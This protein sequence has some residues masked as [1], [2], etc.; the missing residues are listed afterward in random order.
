MRPSVARL[1]PPELDTG[2]Q[3]A[4]FRVELL[5]RY[6]SLRRFLPA[7]LDVMAFEATSAGRAVLDALD[8]L[9]AIEGRTG[10]VSAESVPLQLV[11]GQWK[12]LVLANAQL[13]GG[14][15]DRRAYSFCVLEALQRALDRR[16]V[17]VS[18]SGRYSD[19]RAKLLS[20]PAREAARLEICAS[21]NHHPDPAHALDRLGAELDGAYRPDRRP[22][23]SSPISTRLN[24]ETSSS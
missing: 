19:P 21:L 14:E 17:F 3:D 10:R 22:P 16:D 20:G 12:R 15:L 9:H 13:G 8:A 4:A 1:T 5:R 2:G 7:L 24:A 18:R 23:S 6:P 11:G